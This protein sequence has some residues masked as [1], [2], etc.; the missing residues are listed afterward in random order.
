MDTTTIILISAVLVGAIVIGFL[1]LMPKEEPAGALDTSSA[2]KTMED[3]N[4]VMSSSAGST[5][6]S[7]PS[8]PTQLT[9]SSQPSQGT[10]PPQQPA[11]SPVQPPAQLSSAYIQAYGEGYGKTELE[12]EEIAKNNGLKNLTEQLYV[13]VKTSAELKE[14]L[15]TVIQDGKVREKFESQY[16]KTI[17]TKTEFELTGVTYRL[18]ERKQSGNQYYAKVQVYIEAEKAKQ[19]L[20]AYIAINIGKT[21]LDNK[22]V[23]TAKNIADKY[24]PL[25]SQNVFPPKISEEL[26]SLI[27]Q[28]KS[29]YDKV[30]G[31]IK[32][33][34]SAQVRDAQTAFDAADLVNQLFATV[35]D[36]PANL[37]DTEKLRPYLKDVKISLSGPKEVL[38]G[39]QVKVEVKVEPGTVKSL[40]VYG[41][42]I[43]TQDLVTLQ[44]GTAVLSAIVK[45]PNSKLNVS[46]S[47]IV[48]SAWAPGS[49]TQDPDILRTTYKGEQEIKIIAGGTSKI[50]S[51]QKLM[52]ENAIKDAL[53][54]T[55]KKVASELLAGSDRELLDIPIDDYILGKVVGAID[56]EITATGEYSGL[57]YVLVS[58]TISK[59]VFEAY[60]KDALRNAPSGFAM[61]ITEGDTLG[62]VEPALI[63]ELTRSKINLVSKDFSKKVL[64]TQAKTNLPPATLAKITAL[65]AA[66]YLLYV[67]VNYTSTYLSDY[68]VYSVRTLVTTQII[69]TITGNILAA[70]R[71]EETNT[72]ATEQAAISKTVSGQKFKDY[73]NE[74]ISSL[75]FENVATKA[76]YRYTFILEKTIYGS[77]L[78]DNLNAKFKDMKVIEKVDT[79]L[80]VELENVPPSDFERYLS[81]ID[82]LKIKKTSDNTYQ[83]TK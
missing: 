43:E 54:K 24:E 21:L 7:T 4:K 53:V 31:L 40:F 20:E 57:Y 3:I 56:Y 60:I 52:R 79:K 62:Y 74:L 12:A 45:A 13:Q 30:Q 50:L 46:L 1:F 27:S 35:N 34:N 29:K 70:P 6:P 23:F 82:V 19:A 36:L 38:L 51:D 71:F 8:Q 75:R 55:I 16:E 28:I 73:V 15:T 25:L 77:I 18:V 32:N 5:A 81:S 2:V 58:S 64:E 47:G 72:G 17:Q 69:D 49:V 26:T 22:M 10:Q 65:S 68:K 41:D 67:T 63:D 37:I 78:L 42:N 59:D 83:V 76:A 48:E 39:E 11:T 14:K 66:R 33:I 9:Q 80:I 61:I 44:N